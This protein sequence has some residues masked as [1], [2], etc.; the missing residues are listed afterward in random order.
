MMNRSLTRLW[1]SPPRLP[2][3]VRVYAV[4]DVH[5]H[6]ARL[7]D[8]HA[9]IRTE[10][11]KYPVPNAALVHIGDMID[12]GPDSAGV[13]S[14][15]CDTPP[16]PG[17]QVHNLVGNHEAMLL[18]AIDQRDQ[19]GADHWLAHGG[20]ETLLSWGIPATTPVQAWAALLPPAHLTLL[21]GLEMHWTAGQY[22]FVHA[23]VKPGTALEA[24]VPEDLLWIREPF[25]ER[26]GPML[27]EAPLQ[28]IVHGHSPRARPEVRANRINL[29]TGAGKGGRLTCA[30]LEGNDIRFLQA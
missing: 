29:D 25:L 2:P 4:G 3:G 13:L 28:V 17:L 5:G 23:G 19:S 20:A 18:A 6:L 30:V 26:V 12:R 24:Q 7:L 11:A 14:V 16:A 15:L 22:L 21:R 9:A 27:P 1:K 8:L 10:L